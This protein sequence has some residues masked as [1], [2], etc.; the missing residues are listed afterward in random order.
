[1]FLRCSLVA[2]MGAGLLAL[3]SPG[4]H[5]ATLV[6]SPT[7]PG[8]FEV[9]DSVVFGVTTSADFLALGAVAFDLTLTY[10]ANDLQF[11]GAVIV[12]PILQLVAPVAP[13]APSG[14]TT[15]DALSG[16]L[17]SGFVGDSQLIATFAFM[18]LSDG[19][20][21]V[22]IAPMFINGSLPVPTLVFTD[23]VSGS[24]T[25]EGGA[26]AVV[27]LPAPAILLLSALGAFPPLRRRRLRRREMRH[28]AEIHPSGA[29]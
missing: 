4:A 11:M 19:L 2:M 22:E 10:D 25:V 9:G 1:M 3:T 20:A 15:L 27:P 8:P 17:L 6:V 12:S 18:A 24:V 14:L 29:A 5:A 7:A 16:G 28:D 13:A 26:S 21:S 23:L